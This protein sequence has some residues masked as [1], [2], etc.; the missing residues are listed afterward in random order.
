[1]SILAPIAILVLGA[2]LKEELIWQI[3]NH[4]IYM[5]VKLKRLIAI[6]QYLITWLFIIYLFS[7]SS[8]ATGIK[9]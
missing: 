1:M 6:M 8:S 7:C 9:D 2:N 4:K 5:F 3:Y